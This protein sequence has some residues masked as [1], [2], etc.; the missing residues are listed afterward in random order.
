MNVVWDYGKAN[1]ESVKGTVMQ[2]VFSV[3][4]Q[5]FRAYYPKN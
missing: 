3:Y 2:I 5:N 1:C 4:K